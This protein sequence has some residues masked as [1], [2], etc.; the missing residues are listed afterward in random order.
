[1]AKTITA[2]VK[3]KLTAFPVGTAAAG[4]LIT[5]RPTNGDQPI[6]RLFALSSLVFED[7]KATLS[8][9]DVPAGTYEGS[10]GL[11]DGS[12]AFLAP[13]IT[14]AGLIEVTEPA[15]VSFPV[16]FSLTLA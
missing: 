1:M 2:E 6:Q 5:L 12:S 13:A 10:I 15:T 3:S 16:P 11:V 4:F 8:I 9:P 14:A 7:D